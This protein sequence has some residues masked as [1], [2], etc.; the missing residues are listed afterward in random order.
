M[1]RHDEATTPRRFTRPKSVE[2][3][4]ALYPKVGDAPGS[5]CGAGCVPAPQKPPSGDSFRGGGTSPAQRGGG[6]GRRVSEAI[7]LTDPAESHFS[8]RFG[9]EVAGFP[10]EGG[11]FPSAPARG[12]GPGARR[13]RP[14]RACRRRRVPAE[15]GAASPRP[16]P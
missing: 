8:V 9:G 12:T 5:G 2:P 7:Q 6:G 14:A 10:S 16:A 4:A 1:S 15:P 3:T 13:S 11:V